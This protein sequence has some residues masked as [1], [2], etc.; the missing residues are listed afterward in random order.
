MWSVQ[1]TLRGHRSGVFCVAVLPDRRIVTGSE[2]NTVKVW[3]E[4]RGGG[5]GLWSVE[6][7]LPGHKSGVWCVAVFPDG[8]FATGSDDKTVKIWGKKQ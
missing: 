7:T 4:S 5:S 1:A 6:A 2:D 3:K 8:R